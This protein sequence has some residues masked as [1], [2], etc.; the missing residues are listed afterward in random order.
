MAFKT[1]TSSAIMGQNLDISVKKFKAQKLHILV[2]KDMS[3]Q[4]RL[5]LSFIPNRSN[6][7]NFPDIL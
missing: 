2:H 7:P 3:V 4:R 6:R 1:R 5:R